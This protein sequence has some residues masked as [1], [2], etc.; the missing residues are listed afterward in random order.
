MK[1]KRLIKKLLRPKKV[2]DPNLQVSPLRKNDTTSFVFIHI[3]KTAGTSIAK[4]IGLPRKR[5]LTAKE[6][7]DIIGRE[8]WDE[9]FKFAVVRNPWAKVY[10]HYKYRIKTNQNNMGEEPIKFN[11]WVAKTYGPEKDPNFY[12]IPTMFQPQVDWL[13]DH[14]G[15]MDMDL[16]LKFESLATDY[17]VLQQKIGIDEPLPHLNKTQKTDYREQYSEAS[18]EIIA[19]WFKEDIALF[20]YR[21]D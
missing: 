9:A 2:A 14:E 3:N 19:D 18:K 20:G 4:A 8:Q 21:F 15:K 10:S 17:K 1:L 6:V 7:I 12:D 16:I 11:D 13:K 5:H